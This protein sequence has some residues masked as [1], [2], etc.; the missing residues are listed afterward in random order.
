METHKQTTGGQLNVYLKAKI[1]NRPHQTTTTQ[2]HHLAHRNGLGDY[3]F[4]SWLF[5]LPAMTQA[6]SA[7]GLGLA[8][9]PPCDLGPGVGSDE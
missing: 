9:S 3:W 8:C 1:R 6:Q 2:N 7:P 5:N 4:S